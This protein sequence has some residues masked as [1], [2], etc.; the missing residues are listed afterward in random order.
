MNHPVRID[1]ADHV[2]TDIGNVVAAGVVGQDAERRVER[3]VHGRELFWFSD[4][5]Q[6]ESVFSNAVFERALDMR[7]TFRGLS[8]LRKLIAKHAHP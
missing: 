7:S 1:M 3:G 6:S 4:T 5:K 2:R 8:T